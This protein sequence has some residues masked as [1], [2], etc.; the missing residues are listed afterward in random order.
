MTK[1]RAQGDKKAAFSNASMP[2]NDD[3]HA[4]HYATVVRFLHHNMFIL[5]YNEL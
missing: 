1:R 2:V 5:K 4:L 3:T